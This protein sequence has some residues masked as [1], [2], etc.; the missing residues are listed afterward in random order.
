METKYNR[1]ED[2]K[3]VDS[4]LKATLTLN[5]CQTL[6]AD[7]TQFEAVYGYFKGTDYSLDVKRTYSEG[8]NHPVHSFLLSNK[9]KQ[10][11]FADIVV[12]SKTLVSNHFEFFYSNLKPIDDDLVATIS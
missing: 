2:Q 7:D 9:Y 1:F 11:Y 3:F 6:V 4:S 5:T 8:W 10:M 12:L